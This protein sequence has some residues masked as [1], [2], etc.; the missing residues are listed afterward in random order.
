MR[1]DLGGFAAEQNARQSFAA[2]RRHHDQVAFGFSGLLDDRLVRH[3]AGSRNA[4]A[5][6]A[7]C[8][9]FGLDLVHKQVRSLQT[10]FIKAFLK[11]SSRLRH[12]TVIHYELLI[13]QYNVDSGDVGSERFCELYALLDRFA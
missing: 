5:L 9:R 6:D 4:L 12:Q 10:V 13:R 8:I 2:V 7:G 11:I 3:A 1:E